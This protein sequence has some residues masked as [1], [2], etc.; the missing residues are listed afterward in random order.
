MKTVHLPDELAAKAADAAARQNK[1][2]DQVVVAVLS[3]QLDAWK[4][5]EE[6]Q[7][8]AARADLDAFDK[9][10]ARVPDVPPLPGDEKP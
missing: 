3:R 9:I 7:D 10:L 8:R 1:T 5:I 4:G 2:L 6:M